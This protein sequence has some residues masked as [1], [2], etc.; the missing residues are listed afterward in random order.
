M[1]NA[2]TTDENALR[3]EIQTLSSRNAKLAQLLKSSRDKLKDLSAQIDALGEPASTYGIHLGG[4]VGRDAEVFTAGRRMRLK[5]SPEV[6][7]T[8]LVPGALVR[9][10]EGSI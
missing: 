4:G 9:L 3:R 6:A 1:T 8:D 10:G 2:Q 7:D 5:V